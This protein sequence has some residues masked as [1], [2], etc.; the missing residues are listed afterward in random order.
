MVWLP[1]WAGAALGGNLFYRVAEDGEIAPYLPD[2]FDTI[3]PDELA[4]AASQVKPIGRN[5]TARRHKFRYEPL[6]T[7]GR[8][9]VKA[10]VLLKRALAR[11]KAGDGDSG[12]NATGLWLACQLR[13]NGYTQDEAREVLGRFQE[14]VPSG[15]HEYTKREA[16]ATLR[17]A[18]GRP[19][20]Q[21]WRLAAKDNG[22]GH[23]GADPEGNE[24]SNPTPPEQKPAGDTAA[25][26]DPER[27]TKPTQA[28]V[29]LGLAG[30]HDYFHAAGDGRAYAVVRFDDGEGRQILPVRSNAFRQVLARDYYRE[31]GKAPSSGIMQ[32][33]LGV[34]ESRARFDG[35]ARAV[36]VRVLGACGRVY[37]DLGDERW[38]A[39]EIGPDGWRVLADPPVHFR[40]PRGMLALPEPAR[41][42]S[43]S[44]LRQLANVGTDT[45]WRLAV[46]W[47]VQALMPTGPYPVLCVHGEQ[48]AAKSTFCRML[49]GTIDPNLAPLRSAPRDERDLVIA[50]SNSWILALDN[51]SYLDPW[52]SDALC[53]LAT[54]GGYATRELYS[55]SDE[56][57]LDA[58]R[59]ILLNGI[60]ELSTRPDL[61]DRAIVL[62]LPSLDE[63]QRLPEREVWARYEQVRPRVLGALLDTLAG[64]LRHRERVQ[65]PR[66]PRMADFAVLGEAAGVALGWRQGE[67]V[68]A[69]AANRDEQTGTILD[70]SI[71]YPALQAV[72]SVR[73]QWEGTATDLLAQLTQQAG[74][75][76]R[77]R[78]WPGTGRALAGMLRRLA[79]TLRR[80]G[81]A[82]E[83]ARVARQRLIRLT[84][85][86]EESR[87]P[88]SPPSSPSSPS[89]GCGLRDDDGL[90]EPSSPPSPAS[91][92][93]TADR[94]ISA[95]DDG[96]DGDDADSGRFSAGDDGHGDAWEGP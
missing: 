46:A 24:P 29:L 64:A 92:T 28:E 75:R 73:G 82:V 1:W 48:G 3:T 17:S 61:L 88:P 7:D 33:V 44:E 74:D 69:Y 55:D 12:R 70:G 38:R 79:P 39:V 5:G 63:N 49:R 90:P 77:D 67:F 25:T 96:S 50:A 26:S 57:I 21:P 16:E 94:G 76:A 86:P 47:L 85:T 56:T 8:G 45:D 72:V 27:K 32:D 42:G 93:V 35:E 20:R 23:A 41:G 4:E 43:L 9:R 71:V 84:A 81:L 10:D 58:Q 65:L 40:R 14:A 54:G 53:R 18:Y 68:A 30:E 37:L 66:L 80:A 83:F 31:T 95:A 59:P 51:L 34:L 62:T 2:G 11:A 52:L 6:E 19:A 22:D 15:G 91:S 78:G 36:G 89:Q 13:D 87:S 60:E